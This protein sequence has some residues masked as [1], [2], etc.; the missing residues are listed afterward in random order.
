MASADF[1]EL[2]V[3]SLTRGSYDSQRFFIYFIFN[4]G[5]WFTNDYW[6]QWSFFFVVE[7]V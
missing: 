3:F 2:G 4:A 6:Q 1:M 7:K 5:V